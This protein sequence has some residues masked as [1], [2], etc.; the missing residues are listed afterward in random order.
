MALAMFPEPMMLM[1][2]MNYPVLVDDRK[3]D[4][5]PYAEMVDASTNRGSMEA[6]GTELA[7]P[8]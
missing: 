7:E 4:T 2:L 1:P 3:V 6:D 5:Q 8:A